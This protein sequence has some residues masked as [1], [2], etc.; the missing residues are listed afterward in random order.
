MEHFTRYY[1]PE[2]ESHELVVS[3]ESEKD[4]RRAHAIVGK[5]LQC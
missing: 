2:N 4:M 5:H 3:F 1:S